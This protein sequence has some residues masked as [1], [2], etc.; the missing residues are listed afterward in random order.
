MPETPSAVIET[1]VPAVQQQADKVTSDE[2]YLNFSANNSQ[3]CCE[4]QTY[5]NRINGEYLLA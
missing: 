5:N 4:N 3:K 2:I 1:K